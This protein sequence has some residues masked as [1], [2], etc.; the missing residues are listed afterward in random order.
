MLVLLDNT[1][2]TKFRKEEQIDM[3]MQFDTRITNVGTKEESILQAT[4]LPQE[5]RV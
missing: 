5:N 1:I 2:S 4:D 3:H